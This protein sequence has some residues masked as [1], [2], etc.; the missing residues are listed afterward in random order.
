MKLKHGYRTK[1][2]CAYCNQEPADLEWSTV[3]VASAL[4]LLTNLQLVVQ[5]KH[6]RGITRL[7]SKA[8][9]QLAIREKGL[10]WRRRRWNKR[11]GYRQRGQRDDEFETEASRTYRGNPLAWATWGTHCFLLH[12][13]EVLRV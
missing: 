11:S 3:Y 5:G 13:Y 1:S 2:I 10:P 7:S 8:E 12:W 9:F 6:G 4:A